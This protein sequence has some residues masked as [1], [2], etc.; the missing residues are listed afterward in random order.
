MKKWIALTAVLA[1]LVSMT[2]AIAEPMKIT[3]DYND[4][5]VT[6][7]VPEG[8]TATQEDHEDSDL[9]CVILTSQDASKPRYELHISP[10]EEYTGLSLADLPDEDKEAVMAMEAELY[11]DPVQEVLTTPS[12]NQIIFTREGAESDQFASILT[13]Y[14]GF[15]FYEYCAHDDFSPVTEEDIAV[16]HEITHGVQ[17]EPVADTMMP[18][19]E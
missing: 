15:V 14:R 8:F 17:I 11:L 12:G 16:M 18:P 6:I 2:A 9:V 5:D 10:G 19:A 3:E 1:L 4:F 7:E 13:L